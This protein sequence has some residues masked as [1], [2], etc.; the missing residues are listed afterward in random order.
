MLGILPLRSRFGDTD[1]NNFPVSIGQ[2]YFNAASTDIQ[3][4][5]SLHDPIIER[6]LCVAEVEVMSADGQNRVREP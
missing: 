2:L 6:V 5:H 3:I 1:S 4:M